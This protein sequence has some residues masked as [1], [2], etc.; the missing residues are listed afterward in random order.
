MPKT[1]LRTAVILLAAPLLAVPIGASEMGE[2]NLLFTVTVVDTGPSGE[3]NRRSTEILTLSGT[4]GDLVAG[5]KVPIPTSAG[6]AEDSGGAITSYSYQDIG[7]LA[8]IDGRITSEGGV[9]ASGRIEVSSV[10]AGDATAPTIASFSQKFDVVL[11]DG[12]EVTLAVA[13]RPDGGSVRLELAAAIQ[14]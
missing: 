12:A 13:S 8:R 7:F 9:H 3:V 4:R 6:V 10:E 14:R 11:G 5:W 2:T 1:L